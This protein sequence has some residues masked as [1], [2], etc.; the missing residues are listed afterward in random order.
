MTDVNVRYRMNR[1]DRAETL[2]SSLLQVF[3]FC[4]VLF[5]VMDCIHSINVAV[6]SNTGRYGICCRALVSDDVQITST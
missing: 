1:L 2:A 6:K 3:S 5:K 4:F